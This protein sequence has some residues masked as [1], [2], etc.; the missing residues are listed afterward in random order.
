MRQRWDFCSV[1]AGI[2]EP[3]QRGPGL[4]SGLSGCAFLLQLP[5]KRHCICG[6][7]G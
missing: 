6:G 3:P 5:R 2:S 7:G 4:S 1:A